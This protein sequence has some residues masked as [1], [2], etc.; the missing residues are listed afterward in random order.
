MIYLKHEHISSL[1]T[2]KS[3]LVGQDL[4]TCVKTI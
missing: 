1:E 2:L 4:E 3:L